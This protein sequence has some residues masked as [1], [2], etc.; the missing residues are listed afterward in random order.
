MIPVARK[1][2]HPII[3][4]DPPPPRRDGGSCTRR[5][6]SGLGLYS[7]DAQDS[8]DA[9]AL[10][11]RKGRLKVF[12]SWQDDLDPARHRHFIKTCLEE[13]VAQVGQELGLEDANRPELDHDTKN[14]RGMVDIVATILRKIAESAVFV[15]DVTPIG[16]SA[17]GKAVPNPNVLIELGWALR[18]PG[19]SAS[20][21]SSIEPKAGAR[22]ICRSISASAG[23]CHTNSRPAPTGKP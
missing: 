9:Q 4:G 11:R 19:Y 22:K 20:S 3:I 16:R 1:V 18:E 21:P 17:G 5:I 23:R 13:A 14:E 7:I 10:S 6:E 8:I 12:W 15:A 2:W